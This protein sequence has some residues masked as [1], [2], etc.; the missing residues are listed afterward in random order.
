MQMNRIFCGTDP[1]LI[2]SY[3]AD[4]I[5]YRPYDVEYIKIAEEIGV[6]SADIDNTEIIVLSKDESIA[7]LLPSRK[8]QKLSKYAD[9]KDA[10]SACYAN[11]IRALSRL[12]DEG[13]LYKFKSNPVLIG[14]GYK[15]LGR[16]GD[17]RGAMRFRHMQEHRRLSAS[18]SAILDFLKKQCS[19][20]VFVEFKKG[21][22]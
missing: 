7:K 10:C 22:V 11:L 1:V 4:N 14:Q 2:D 9:A 5:G 13:L 19:N 21:R 8:V 12:D 6:G 16:Q 20:G 3:I 15:G 18:T 17:W